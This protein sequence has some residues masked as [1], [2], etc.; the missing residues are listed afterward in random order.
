MEENMKEIA[1]AVSGMETVKDILRK[2]ISEVGAEELAAAY[3]RAEDIKRVKFKSSLKVV[4]L[5]IGNVNDFAPDLP[6]EQKEYFSG[7]GS[8][9]IVVHGFKDAKKRLRSI[10][11]STRK[12][13]EVCS[14]GGSDLMNI[15]TL[16]EDF[17]PFFRSKQE[18]LES[19][20]NHLVEDVFDEEMELFTK[21]VESVITRLPDP[22]SRD[23]ARK[24]LAGLKTITAKDLVTGTGMFIDTDFDAEHISNDDLREVLS[25]S[26]KEYIVR[27]ATNMLHGMLTDLWKATLVYWQA[28]YV[29]GGKD[30]G[31][32]RRSQI[33]FV[34]LIKK[35]KRENIKTVPFIDLLCDQL[36][37]VAKDVVE[38]DLEADATPILAN[39][40]G[41]VVIKSGETLPLGQLPKGLTPDIL[42][43]IYARM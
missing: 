36:L 23:A 26:K 3:Q 28:V 8:K 20:L 21:N 17:L 41:E 37:N 9:P 33:S 29:D 11:E 32:L 10:I 38:F 19:V 16:E 1:A 39:I 35:V 42:A 30:S 24:R 22:A 6:A 43:D 40:Y 12:R 14:I 18:E 31:R 2:G 27:E 34:E 7:G 15:T 5:E 4:S 25:A 13:A